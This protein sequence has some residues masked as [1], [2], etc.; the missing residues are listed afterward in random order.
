[1]TAKQNIRP[2]EMLFECLMKE[3]EQVSDRELSLTSSDCDKLPE[4]T[5]L[6]AKLVYI[7]PLSVS[8]SIIHQIL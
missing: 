3:L 5:I 6:L 2:N 1:M 8:Q 7:Y 4:V